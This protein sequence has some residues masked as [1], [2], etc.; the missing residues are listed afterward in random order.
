[1]ARWLG[2]WLGALLLAG[3]ATLAGISEKPRVSLKSVEP[4]EVGFFEQRFL[5]RL[6]VENPN[7]VTI[8]IQGLS[9]SVDLNGQHFADGLSD[10]AVTLPALGEAVLE[11]KASTSLG[12]VLR[13][14]RELSNDSRTA[15]DYHI[16]GKLH[17]AGLGGVPFE[18]RGQIAPDAVLGGG[19]GKA[20]STPKT[21]ASK[22]LPGSI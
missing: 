3:C 2:L 16:T 9:F 5:L 10:K 1:M 21:P 20:P 17:G 13:Q 15:L 18:S 4:L 14:L 11:V 12:R 6:R 7:P 22:P 8:P 19:P